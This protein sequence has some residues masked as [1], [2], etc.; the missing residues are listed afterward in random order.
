VLP[1]Y[2]PPPESKKE[3]AVKHGHT[4][5]LKRNHKRGAKKEDLF[6]EIRKKSV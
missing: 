5:N 2:K 6:A 1:E 4:L 3:K